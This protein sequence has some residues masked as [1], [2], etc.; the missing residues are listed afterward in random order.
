MV[1]LGDAQHLMAIMPKSSWPWVRTLLHSVLDQPDA[2]SV[3]A[4]LTAL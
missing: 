4:Q 1:I 3:C 2:E